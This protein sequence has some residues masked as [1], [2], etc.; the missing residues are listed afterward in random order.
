[1]TTAIRTERRFWATCAVAGAAMFIA[2]GV[3]DTAILSH[4]APAPAPAAGTV[5][6]NRRDLASA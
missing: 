2:I 4:I 1:M 6:F 5:A 3:L